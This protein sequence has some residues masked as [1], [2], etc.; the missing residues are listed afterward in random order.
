MLT[1][2][3]VGISTATYSTTVQCCACDERP[4]RKISQGRKKLICGP[5]NEE[6]VVGGL[7]EVIP[8]LAWTIPPRYAFDLGGGFFLFFDE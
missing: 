2:T 7:F 1:T 4:A 8:A 6:L 5:E 3:R